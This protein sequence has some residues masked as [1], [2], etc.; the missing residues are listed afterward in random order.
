MFL[1]IL[2]LI[3]VDGDRIVINLDSKLNVASKSSDE[4]NV[5]SLLMRI[6]LKNERNQQY[7]GSIE[8][9]TPA[10]KI[11]SV[12]F[13][14]GSNDLWIFGDKSKEFV[15]GVTFFDEKASSSINYTSDPFTITYVTG[16]ASGDVVQDDIHLGDGVFTAVRFGLVNIFSQCL[17]S[18]PDVCVSNYNDCILNEDKRCV[19]E[20]YPLWKEGVNGIMGL[21]YSM[22]RSTSKGILVSNGSILERFSF[23]LTRS[24]ASGSRMI[25]GDP[26]SAL[27]SGPWIRCPLQEST[28]SEFPDWSIMISDIRIDRRHLRLSTPIYAAVDT[29][30]SAIGV[31]TIFWEDQLRP[32]LVKD[33]CLETEEDLLCMG[34]LPD[35][36]FIVTDIDGDH[37]ELILKNEDYN[38]NRLSVMPIEGLYDDTGVHFIFGTTVLHK[39][40]TEFNY[41][42]RQI[43]FAIRKNQ[44]GS[45]VFWMIILSSTVGILTLIGYTWHRVS[46]RRRSP[47]E[48]EGR[49][50]VYAPGTE[51]QLGDINQS[52]PLCAFIPDEEKKEIV[53]KNSTAELSAPVVT[54]SPIIPA[55]NMND[56]QSVETYAGEG[57]C[58]VA[59]RG[60]GDS[61]TE[62]ENG[63]KLNEYREKLLSSKP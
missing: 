32:A 10:Q 30:T 13:D 25:I 63:R 45:W 5:G 29:G 57:T 50:Q 54:E 48:R 55:Y 46:S 37:R 44:Q 47:V 2:L 39:F 53:N 61:Y 16:F 38:A 41:R 58:E 7:L 26:D 4:N 35:I 52:V 9:G 28:S 3:H 33:T 27:F 11:N 6:G 31:D 14:T 18:E 40:Y 12:L 43:N 1:L 21:G 22:A 56:V 20:K 8:V 17:D 60:H 23:Y 51:E 42:D 34:E 15:S 19:D 59:D 62:P 24:G 36:A 49:E